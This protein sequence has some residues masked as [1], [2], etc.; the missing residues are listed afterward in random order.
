MFKNFQ[1]I[2]Y[3]L[4]KPKLRY[5]FFLICKR[6][7]INLFLIFKKNDLDEY[8]ISRINDIYKYLNIYNIDNP[9]IL[10]KDIFDQRI[11]VVNTNP[12]NFG[13]EADLELLFNISKHQGINNILETGVANGW[14]SLAILLAI[15]NDRY[16]KLT[17]IDLPY[18]YK[19]SESFIGKA[20][21]DNLKE[22][23]NLII[24][25]D[26]KILSKFHSQEIKFDFVHY[27]SDKSY[28]GR[29]KSYNLIWNIL[30]PGGILMSDDVSDN[31]A[32]IF[33]CS[34]K[35]LKPLIYEFEGKQIG[36]IK[37]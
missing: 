19:D 14:S 25:N 21:P 37:K 2:I 9:K 23:W 7:I 4:I 1:Y 13:G 18:P 17:S 3:Y 8:K 24:D 11:K 34:S 22:N 36:I 33:F 32:F 28:D 29:I 6:K 31:N 12:Y 5:H 15:N 16:K 20:V 26:K 10:F 27:D 35:N 30:Q